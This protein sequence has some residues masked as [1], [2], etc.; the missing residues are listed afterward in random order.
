MVAGIQA[1]IIN[2]DL[3]NNIVLTNL[4]FQQRHLE[5]HR[6]YNCNIHFRVGSENVSTLG[7]HNLIVGTRV[8]QQ[9][10]SDGTRDRRR[11]ARERNGRCAGTDQ[12][13]DGDVSFSY[14]TF[15]PLP[16]AFSE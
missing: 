9:D 14:S 16:R 2:D 8:L 4:C 1:T 5:W 11:S 7:R 12:R 13:I 10:K 3:V 6:S 15:L